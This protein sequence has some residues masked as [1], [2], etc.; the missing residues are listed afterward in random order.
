MPSHHNLDSIFH[1]LWEKKALERDSPGDLLFRMVLFQ[2]SF[3]GAAAT[4]GENVVLLSR[5]EC[6]KF[7]DEPLFRLMGILMSAVSQS[8]L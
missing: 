2:R 3:A 5:K 6:V 1:I 8:V 4:D 7:C